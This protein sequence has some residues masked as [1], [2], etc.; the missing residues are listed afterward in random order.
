MKKWAKEELKKERKEF[1]DKKFD[2][3]IEKIKEANPE[4]AAKMIEMKKNREVEN[5]KN[6]EERKWRI[7]E[8]QWKIEEIK[9]WNQI[10]KKEMKLKRDVIWN[11]E[12]KVKKEAIQNLKE[13]NQKFKEVRQATRKK[14]VWERRIDEK[15]FRKE[16]FDKRQDNRIKNKRWE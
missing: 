7:E 15:A 11:L 13:E 10:H 1:N 14:V 9:K 4:A 12:W 2:E 8:F 3:K 6:R 16:N 5:L